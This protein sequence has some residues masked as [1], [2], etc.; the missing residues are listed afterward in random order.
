MYDLIKTVIAN[1]T[2]T[3]LNVLLEKLKRLWVQG[4]LTEAQYDELVAMTREN[5]P[6]KAY[7]I[8][9]EIDRL[10]AAVHDLDARLAALAQPA[11]EPEPGAEPEPEPVTYPEWVQPTGAH[12]A[13]QTG[14]RVLYN[15][16]VYESV[17]N[18]NVWAPDVYPAGWKEPSDEPE[19][20][21]E[22]GEE[23]DPTDPDEGAGTAG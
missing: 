12:D 16:V 4:D 2:Y 3:D 23:E 13:Y 8:Q 11:E 17:I 6:V 1:R 19:T 10:W 9:A 22:T 14:D 21:A 20:P 18:G 5:E 7:E 15:G